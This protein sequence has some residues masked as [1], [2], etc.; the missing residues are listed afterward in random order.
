MARWR[1]PPEYWWGYSWARW[2]GV[3]DPH[4]GQ[5][6]DGP[7]PGR[8]P[9]DLLVGLDHLGH[10]VAD[11]EDGVQRR[12]RILED[13][14]DLVAPQG[15]QLVLAGRQQVPP[16]EDDATRDLRLRLLEEAH[17]GQGRDRLP[18]ARLPHDA[19]RLAR[20]DR[21]AHPVDRLD[22]AGVGVELD[23]EVFD[24]NERLA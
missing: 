23:V 14:R 7:L 13:H 12:E 1:I 24:G 15:P 5:E 10:L 20:G 8:D 19:Q 16:P 11:F 3:G 22:D 2:L 21:P 6:V 18:R 9:A 4:L 17:D